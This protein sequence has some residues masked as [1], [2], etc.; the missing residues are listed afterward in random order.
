MS[1]ERGEDMKRRLQHTVLP[2]AHET[3][4]KIE[5]GWEK[6]GERLIDVKE[7]RG[8]GRGEETR[9]MKEVVAVVAV[10]V[11]V[12][13]VV[14]EEEEEEE[15]KGK[16]LGRIRQPRNK[17]SLVNEFTWNYIVNFMMLFV[18]AHRSLRLLRTAEPQQKF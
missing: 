5:N 9:G 2:T 11:V 6:K 7:C 15:I 17:Y 10:V 12:V 8:E 3:P 18:S 1:Q 16:Q 13:V 4:W 14:E